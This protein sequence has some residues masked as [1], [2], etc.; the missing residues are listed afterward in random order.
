MGLKDKWPGAGSYPVVLMAA[1][2]Q[3]YKRECSSALL[4]VT[5]GDLVVS[6]LGVDGSLLVILEPADLLQCRKSCGLENEVHIF[7]HFSSF[8]VI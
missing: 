2:F 8:L 1:V 3:E 7:F 5:Q 4:G 6:G